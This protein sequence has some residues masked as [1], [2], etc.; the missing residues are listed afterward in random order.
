MGY[1]NARRAAAGLVSALA[2]VLAT[3]C[4]SPA[5]ASPTVV[6]F[7][8]VHFDPFFDPAL[9]AALQASPESQWA[10]ILAGAGHAGP[11][12]YGHTTNYTLLARSLAAIQALRPRPT[13][14]VFEG[15]LLVQ[16]FPAAYRAVSG[17]SD[18]AAMRAFALKTVTFVAHQIRA[19]LGTTP[20]YFTLGNWDNYAG[21]FLL[22]PDDPFLAD[23]AGL[24]LDG[25]LLGTADRAA[26]E[27]TYPSGG[28]YAAEAPGGGLVVI[29]LN[30]IFLAPQAPAD[31]AAAVTR[32]L[33]WLEI[34]L[35]AVRAS[36]RHAWI[37]THVP[38]G[39]DLAT[40]SKDVGADGKLAGSTM[41]LQPGPQER[42][43]AILAAYRDVV[44]TAFTGHT[45]MDEFRIAAIPMQGIP[46]ITALLGN[47]PSFKVFTTS[48]GWTLHDYAS[49]ALDLSVPSAA[50][51]PYYDF[52]DAYGLV[53]PLGP[54]LEALA[55]GLRAS[56][57]A[58]TGYLGRYGSGHAPSPP[59]TGVNAPV[60]LCGVTF[61]GSQGLTGCVNGW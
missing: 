13:I 52:A 46:G 4:S 8:D 60:Y 9:F 1:W 19:A 2:T 14:A 43:L 59:I 30:T 29:G 37:V 11:G 24:F 44:A 5:P 33:D 58:R 16:D 31:A 21:S 27:S 32:E 56:P 35:A 20:V 15:D 57:G 48:D 25:M 22:Q 55:A 50:F 28:Y 49:W 34:T 41:M 54:S 38:P 26:F 51:Q 7:G 40:T 39:G 42:Y 45:H 3:G 17:S 23:T 47:S 53:P 18:P 6:A 36:G 12:A 61:M 10:G